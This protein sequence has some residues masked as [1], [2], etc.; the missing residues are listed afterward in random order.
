MRARGTRSLQFVRY[1]LPESLLEGYMLARNAAWY[2]L[3]SSWVTRA[4]DLFRDAFWKVDSVLPHS[5]MILTK[6]YS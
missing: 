2:R 5:Y 1:H 6:D 3:R 4:V